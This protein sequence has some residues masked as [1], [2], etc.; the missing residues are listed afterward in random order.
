MNYRLDLCDA[1]RQANHDSIR[2]QA[3][4]V[5][6]LKIRCAGAEAAVRELLGRCEVGQAAEIAEGL[7]DVRRIAEETEQAHL[8]LA[9]LP[10]RTSG[11]NPRTRGEC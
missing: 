3:R 7:E 2:A 5:E 4:I 10:W 8:A 1:C 6:R 9:M 11:S